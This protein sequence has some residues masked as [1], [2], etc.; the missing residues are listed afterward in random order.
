MRANQNPKRTRNGRPGE[1]S[2]T[3]VVAGSSLRGMQSGA[4]RRQAHG[5]RRVGG[6]RPTRAGR[7]CGA[8]PPCRSAS[9]A[10]RQREMAESHSWPLAT[11]RLPDTTA[12]HGRDPLGERGRHSPQRVL[13]SR[14]STKGQQQPCDL[15]ILQRRELVKQGCLTLED[16]VKVF[17]DEVG[18]TNG[19]TQHDEAT[20]RWLECRVSDPPMSL[21]IVLRQASGSNASSVPKGCFGSVQLQSRMGEKVVLEAATRICGTVRRGCN[22]GIVQERKHFL[23]GLQLFL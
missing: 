5:V 19:H 20:L 7:H 1:V 12:R 13:G 3:Q 21:A 10:G 2:P 4:Q 9:W 17:A 14:C 15:G 16:E 6:S 8:K 22:V 11:A 23:A 18:R